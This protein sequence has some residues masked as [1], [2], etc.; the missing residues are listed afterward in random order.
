MRGAGIFAQVG[1][2]R[3]H[4]IGTGN[5]RFGGHPRQAAKMRGF[6]GTRVSH[7]YYEPGLRLLFVEKGRE[8]DLEPVN[9]WLSGL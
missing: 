3:N 7:H 4:T 5:G 9:G 2:D 8:G 6:R 1:I